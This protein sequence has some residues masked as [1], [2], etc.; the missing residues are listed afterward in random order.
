MIV[1]STLTPK[2]SAFDAAVKLRADALYRGVADLEQL[3]QTD[4]TLNLLIDQLIEIR[5]SFNDALAVEG[6]HIVGDAPH[7]PFYFDYIDS[8]VSNALAFRDADHSFIGVTIPLVF[9][10][11]KISL[12]LSSSDAVIAGIGLPGQCNREAV[13]GILFWMLLGFV[14]SHEYAHHTHGHLDGAF[15]GDDAEVVAGA[16]TGSL[17]RQAREADADAWAAY[18]TLSHWVLR[19]GQRVIVELL[20]LQ[21]ASNEAK[22]DVAFACFVVAQAAFTF[23]REPEPLTTNTIR[24]RTHPPQAVRLHLMSRFVL[25]FSSEFR[26][27][28][29]QTMTQPRYQ[30]LMDTV[31]RLMWTNGK[32]APL[33]RV[34]AEF[35]RTPDGVSY[36]DALIAELDLFRATLRRWQAEAET[37]FT[38]NG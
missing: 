28:I 15:D 6:Q 18:L 10:V 5:Q 23:L 26:P 35:L 4:A 36:Q 7:A 30:S 19:D 24:F 22:D 37:V 38:G 34:Q 25:K 13:Q 20:K 14:I 32:H 27:H 12:M 3:R 31:S 9:D 29:R 11:T 16:L 2:Q 21:H 1:K 33:W 17:R 8:A